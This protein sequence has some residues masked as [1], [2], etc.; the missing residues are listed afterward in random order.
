[1]VSCDRRRQDLDRVLAFEFRVRRAVDLAHAAGTYGG[2]HFI[3]AEAGAGSEGPRWR[4]YMR[5]DRA[6]DVRPLEGGTPDPEQFSMHIRKRCYALVSAPA[7]HPSECLLRGG[8]VL[9]DGDK[10]LWLDQS[11]HPVGSLTGGR[12]E[13]ARI[14]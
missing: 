4:E 7:Q 12:R 10:G 8:I 14:R 13:G 5:E 11:V 1:V 6:P 2:D 3:G 9:D